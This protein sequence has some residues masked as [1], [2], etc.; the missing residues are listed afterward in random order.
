MLYF[1]T[2]QLTPCASAPGHCSSLPQ[3]TLASSL[4]LWNAPWGSEQ[5][6][7]LLLSVSWRKINGFRGASASDPAGFCSFTSL[8]VDLSHHHLKKHICPSKTRPNATS[9]IFIETC[10]PS[11]GR[12]NHSSFPCLLCLMVTC[13]SASLGHEQA[14]GRE[15]VILI[16]IPQLLTRN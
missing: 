4:G 5:A 2:S 9:G 13:L 6:A 15:H 10:V 3:A 16:V 1:P 8:G 11:P 7:R 14:D 12:I